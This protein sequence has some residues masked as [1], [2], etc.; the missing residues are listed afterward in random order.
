MDYLETY[1]ELH[2]DPTNRRL[3]SIGIPLILISLGLLF[4]SWRWAAVV[5]IFGWALQFLGHY[6]EGKSPAFFSNLIFFLIGPYWW[7]RKLLG[8]EKE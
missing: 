7:V 8:L 6:F 5:F 3:H 1:R 4:V 2:R